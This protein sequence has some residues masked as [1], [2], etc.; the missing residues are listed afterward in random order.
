MNKTYAQL[1]VAP[2][3]EE[4]LLLLLLGL[5]EVE[6]LKQAVKNRQG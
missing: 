2:V 4:V 5:V 1:M 3:G 6:V